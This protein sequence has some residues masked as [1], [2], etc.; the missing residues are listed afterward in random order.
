MNQILSKSKVTKIRLNMLTFWLPVRR[1]YQD[2]CSKLTPQEKIE[3]ESIFQLKQKFHVFW[4][5]NYI[6]HSYKVWHK[7]SH[8]CFRTYLW[9]LLW[10]IANKKKIKILS[11]ELR[12]PAT[13]AH[14]GANLTNLLRLQS[15]M[16]LLL[17]FFR[18]KS[19]WW[20]CCWWTHCCKMCWRYS[21]SMHVSV[22]FYLT[23]S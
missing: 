4:K 19:C 17:N 13:Y 16:F 1:T 6:T 11:R 12:L 15:L 8:E 14:L 23:W 22:S 3:L 7:L 9:F 5:H 20:F 18:W 21:Q 2:L 10:I